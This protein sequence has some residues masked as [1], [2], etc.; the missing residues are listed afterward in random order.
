MSPRLR[1]L[2]SSCT[3]WWITRK[4]VRCPTLARTPHSVGTEQTEIGSGFHCSQS[5]HSALALRPAQPVPLAC[6][7][8][9]HWQH[10]QSR[11]LHRAGARQGDCLGQRREPGAKRGQH[12]RPRGGAYVTRRHGAPSLRGRVPGLHAPLAVRGT[13]GALCEPRGVCSNTHSSTVLPCSS[14]AP[15]V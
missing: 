1:R 10:L 9:H 4:S 7:Q 14:R 6:G 8:L 15:T 13:P 2:P 11:R 5:R 3:C 12:T